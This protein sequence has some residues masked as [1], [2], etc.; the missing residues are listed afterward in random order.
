MSTDEALEPERPAP[1]KIAKA[2]EKVQALRE[3]LDAD[4]HW[5]EDGDPR[6]RDFPQRLRQGTLD[7]VICFL[8]F[9]S[10]ETTRLCNAAARDGLPA[11]VLPRGY[12]TRSI[13]RAVVELLDDSKRN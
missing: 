2:L 12:G 1:S 7:A 4:V 5:I 8:R 9:S 10:H 13:L 3:R 6:A 11:R